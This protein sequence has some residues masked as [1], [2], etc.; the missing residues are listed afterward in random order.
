MLTGS[1][2]LSA[3]G[4]AGLASRADAHGYL[5]EPKPSW[6]DG[7]DGNV[8]WITQVDNY[9]DIG[10]GGDQ[11]G[12]FK[13]MAAEKGMSVKDVVL[14]MVGSQTC[15]NTLPDGDPQPIPSDGKAKWLG[16]EGGGFTHTGPCEIYLDDKMVLHS[17]DCE[18][19][20]KGGPVGSTQTSDMP[21]DYSSCNGK[22]LF[23]IYWLAF[24]NAQ[25]QTYINCVPLTGSGGGGGSSTTQTSSSTSSST[26][27]QSTES[28]SADTPST[29]NKSPSTGN[30]SPE[31]PA[32]TTPTPDSP[33]TQAPSADSPA[34]QAPSADSPAAEA[35][36]KCTPARR[37]LRKKM[38]A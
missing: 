32:A 17:D 18:D 9:W 6:K 13:T 38:A 26:G 35:E 3:I 28:S 4:L 2:L 31:P 8:G 33:A 14:D 37:R 27:T 19:E 5:K 10:S 7:G 21:V 16:N 30:D 25:W 29:E 1:L 36:T 23:T 24:Q 12:K 34:T 11:V 15:G 20:F 22:C